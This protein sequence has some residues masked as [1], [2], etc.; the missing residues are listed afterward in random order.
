MPAGYSSIEHHTSVD[1]RAFAVAGPLR[2]THCQN[3]YVTPL[4]VLL[5]LAIF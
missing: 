3:V 4:L 2:G 1:G 5:F